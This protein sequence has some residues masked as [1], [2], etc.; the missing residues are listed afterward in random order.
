MKITTMISFGVGS[1]MTYF[2]IKELS[3]SKVKRSADALK[4]KIAKMLD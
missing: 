4:D 3:K 1:A 2:T